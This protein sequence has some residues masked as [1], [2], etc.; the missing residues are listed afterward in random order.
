MAGTLVCLTPVKMHSL[1]YGTVLNLTF[2]FKHRFIYNSAHEAHGDRLGE[3]RL[4]AQTGDNTSMAT[5]VSL[6]LASHCFS[7]VGGRAITRDLPPLP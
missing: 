2:P 5:C 6:P 4:R 7:L 1:E 3:Y